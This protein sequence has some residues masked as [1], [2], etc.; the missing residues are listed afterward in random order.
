MYFE[1]NG[2]WTPWL[3]VTFEATHWTHQWFSLHWTLEFCVT[4]NV[5]IVANGTSFRRVWI[6]VLINYRPMFW[7]P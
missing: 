7:T 2:V 4:I 6:F 1:A 5:T 3:R